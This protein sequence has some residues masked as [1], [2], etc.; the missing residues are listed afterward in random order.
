M[1]G[2]REAGEDMGTGE[3]ALFA[4]AR[5]ASA[6]F[7]RSRWRLRRGGVRRLADLVA[8]TLEPG[9]EAVCGALGM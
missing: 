6:T 1:A 9:D 8:E 3:P 2:N 5:A 7:G 4:F